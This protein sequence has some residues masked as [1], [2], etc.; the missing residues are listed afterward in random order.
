MTVNGIDENHAGEVAEL[1]S[2]FRSLQR[3]LL[4]TEPAH[5]DL[6]RGRDTASPEIRLAAEYIA[7][8][9]SAAGDR[10]RHLR[11]RL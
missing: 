2:Y 8:R 7:S 5:S 9:L 10:L 6:M 11:S 3:Q 1:L 4:L